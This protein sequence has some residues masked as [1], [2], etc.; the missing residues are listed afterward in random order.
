[1]KRCTKYILAVSLTLPVLG[2]IALAGEPQASP[3]FH[4]D[5]MLG[6][7]WTSSD[8]QLVPGDDNK[9]ITSLSGDGE[10]ES[11]LSPMAM[12]N[13]SYTTQAGTQFFVS[14]DGGFSAG[15]SRDF[16]GM[17]NVTLAGVFQFGEVWEDPYLTGVKRE[18]TDETRTGGRL[19]LDGILGTGLNL[20]YSFMNIEVD[21]DL[22]GKKNA[23]L[24]R[25]GVTHSV[26]TGYAIPLGE[27][28]TLTPQLQYE[29]GDLDGESNSYDSWGGGLTHTYANKD[30]MIATTVSIGMAEYDKSHPVFKKTRDEDTHAVSSTI[31]WLNPLGYDNF[32][33]SATGSYAKT[34]SN[35]DFF[36]STDTMVGMGVG[37]RF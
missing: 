6:G 24:K 21:D 34:D 35:I 19:A 16:A 1:M 18:D 15:V 5:L 4:G 17:A 30:M 36:D 27:S 29:I 8:S 25:D 32:S 9:K 12:G 14:G 7:M 33:L 11:E 13:L 37:Y 31:T 28:N 26:T 3:G 20:G 2:G 10:T 23:L 22:I